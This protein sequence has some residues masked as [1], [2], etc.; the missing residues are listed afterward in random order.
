MASTISNINK[1]AIAQ[2]N[3]ANEVRQ[4]IDP[5]Q[6]TD[7]VW[8]GGNTQGACGAVHAA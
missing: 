7:L 1:C 2:P 3:P 4:D 6:N 5:Q 8:G